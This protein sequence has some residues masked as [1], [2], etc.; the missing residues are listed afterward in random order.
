MP[1]LI[2]NLQSLVHTCLIA[3]LT[4][5]ASPQ[6]A[7]FFCDLMPLLKQACWDTHTNRLVIFV[8]GIIMSISPLSCILLSYICIFW[9]VLKIPSAQGK[10]KASFLH[11]W[12]T[13]HCGVTVLWHH[14]R[15]VLAARISHLFPEGQGG[16]LDV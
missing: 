13:P 10:W 8:F 12:F 5:C 6:I 3:Q 9:V 2:T 1:W 4:F 11:L 16:R 7:H 15:H 14:L